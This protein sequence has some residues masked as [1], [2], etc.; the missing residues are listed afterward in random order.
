MNNHMHILE[1][2]TRPFSEPVLQAGAKPVRRRSRLHRRVESFEMTAK[3]GARVL[4]RPLQPDDRERLRTAF[5]SLSFESRLFRF[6]TPIASLDEEMLRY[7]IEVDQRQRF[8]WCALD[9]ALPHQPLVGTVRFVRNKENPQI[10]EFGLEVIDDYQNR[11]IG[12]ILFLLLYNLARMEDIQILTT[13]VYPT[14]RKF[15]NLL[16]RLGISA[17]L[18]DGMVTVAFPVFQDDV[19]FSQFWPSDEFRTLVEEVQ[20]KLVLSFIS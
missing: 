14:N 17:Q 6:F 2:E 9:P 18:Q 12:K 8:A 1:N 19:L 20:S 10:A 13:Q 11:G 5:N 3:H 16:N 4:L 7:F 15:L